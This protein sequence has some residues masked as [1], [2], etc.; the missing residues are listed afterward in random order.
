M[1]SRVQRVVELYG[2]TMG[3]SRLL[4]I[5]SG[6]HFSPADPIPA[7]GMRLEMLEE[8]AE[9]GLRTTLP[10]TL[11]PRGPL[12][13]DALSLSDEERRLFVEQAEGQSR[14]LELML[15]LGLRDDQAYTCTPYLSEVGNR[16]PRDAVVAWSESSCV[17]Y[18]NS[19]LGARTNRTP[20]IVDLFSNIVG[21]TPEFG[22]LT[23]DGRRATWRIAVTT[24]SLPAPQLLGAFIAGR[25]VADVPYVVGLDALLGAGM[26]AAAED[27]L[28]EMGAACA[29]VGGAV[30]LFHV[31]GITPEAVEHGRRLVVPDARSVTVDDSALERLESQ[32]RAAR[33]GA[34]A[35]ERCVIG[36]PHLSSAELDW[37]VNAI[38]D[39]VHAGGARRVAVQTILSAAPQVIGN[40]LSTAGAG[41]RVA[42]LGIELSPDCLE[43]FMDN[44]ACA[45]RP[46]VTT[47]NKLRAYT[48]ARLLGV[49]EILA[50][51]A[52]A[53]GGADG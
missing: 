4:E 44:P 22:L 24:R 34:P 21:Y 38:A 18:A 33:V 23:D 39:S 28:K 30:G 53:S 26:N 49:D 12:D 11:D 41:R 35:P 8:L 7:V 37:W 20:A 50:V 40:Y 17:V 25:V 32:Y 51:I 19:V 43:A 27:Y 10:F 9:A 6:G 31:E 45:K 5:D 29:A 46:T 15:A 42:E 3:A 47:S 14:Y 52:G 48:T 1:L 2:E 36:C 13:L 16:P